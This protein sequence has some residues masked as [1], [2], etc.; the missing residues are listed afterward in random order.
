LLR[1]APR[2]SE[3]QSLVNL[4]KKSGFSGSIGRSHSDGGRHFNSTPPHE[5]Y[6]PQPTPA[7]PG[8]QNSLKS[9]K[10]TDHTSFL[11]TLRGKKQTMEKEPDVRRIGPACIVF[12]L[13]E[14]T[15]LLAHLQREQLFL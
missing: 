10:R 3:Q 15:C 1:R 4:H 11:A 5:H 13:G 9:K 2:E 8:D 14:F 12:I 7:K 6:R